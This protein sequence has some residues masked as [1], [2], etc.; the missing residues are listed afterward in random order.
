MY[1]G[2]HTS[3]FPG[4]AAS[5]LAAPPSPRH[6]GNVGQVPSRMVKKSASSHGSWRV[7]REIQLGS[8]V[9]LVCL[10]CLVELD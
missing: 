6:E 8:L 2:E 5:P 7:K 3:G 9:Y 1:S 10:V 4:P